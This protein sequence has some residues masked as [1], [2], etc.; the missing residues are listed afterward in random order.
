M[1]SFDAGYEQVNGQSETVEAGVDRGLLDLFGLV[2]RRKGLIAFGLLL[3]LGLVALYFFQATPKYASSVEILVV[4]KDADLPTQG[5]SGAKDVQN[6]SAGEDT[7]ATHI[8]LFQS[9]RVIKDAIQHGALDQLPTLAAVIAKGKN[10][11]DFI[12]DHLVV[13][14]G[15]EGKAKDASV[16][17][18]TYQSTSPEDAAS[19]LSAIVDR[20]Q[21][22]LGDTFENTS[23]QAVELIA[24]A[25]TELGKE[26]EE[27]EEAFWKFR[28]EAP[29]VWKGQTSLNVH[30][31]RLVK[32]EESLADVEIRYTETKARLE[33]INEVLENKDAVTFSDLDKLALLGG[34]DVER[35]KLL[36]A[37]T[38]NDDYR[39][40]RQ[41][42]PKSSSPPRPSMNSSWRTCW[43]NE[44]FL[45]TSARTT[46]M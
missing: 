24:K 31:D 22:F 10:P 23:T 35:L 13:S 44:R 33:V 21:E 3:G 18:A 30:Q 25:K 38:G 6:T 16:L 19:I 32:A 14:R 4:P 15:G 39:R 9:P 40:Y 12:R 20:Y 17:L 29:L 37:A 2:W 36:L 45:R 28:E 34:S 26:L 7:L 42:A 1:V 8:Q 46:L 43:K 41:E 27:T 5:A 11:V